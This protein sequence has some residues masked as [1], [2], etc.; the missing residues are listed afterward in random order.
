M[1]TGGGGGGG[2]GGDTSSDGLSSSSFFGKSSGGLITGSPGLSDFSS[3]SFTGFTSLSASVSTRFW[4]GLISTG[5][6]G[7]VDVVKGCVT[8]GSTG[9]VTTGSTG[10]ST[11]GSAGLGTKGSTGSTGF[12]TT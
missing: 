8:T 11:T 9:L 2:G 10:L 3:S 12:V 4:I 1:S 6:S 5:V 7:F